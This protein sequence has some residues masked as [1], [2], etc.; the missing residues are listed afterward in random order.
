MS[1]AEPVVAGP[2]AASPKRK[3][4]S[5]KAKAQTTTTSAKRVL[6]KKAPDGY[7]PSPAVRNLPTNLQDD[8]LEWWNRYIGE[9]FEDALGSRGSLY[10]NGRE[11]VLFKFYDEFIPDVYGDINW[12]E[13]DKGWYYQQIGLDIYHFLHRRTTRGGKLFVP[14]EQKVPLPKKY[15]YAHDEWRNNNPDI[16]N[17]ILAKAVAE[18]GG[19]LGV[20]PRQ[21][22]SRSE[23]KKLSKDEQSKW[24]QAAK[25]RLTT[26]NALC[27]LENPEE[28]ERQGASIIKRLLALIK[29]AENTLGIQICAQLL[30]PQSKDN[31]K[32]KSLYARG[33]EQFA[34]TGSLDEFLNSLS[35]YVEEN[36]GVSVEG[37]PARVSILPDFR[38]DKRPLMPEITQHTRLAALQQLLRAYITLLWIFQGGCTKVP[39]D[40]IGKDIDNWIDPMRRPAS[41]SWSDPGS[42]P[43]THVLQWFQYIQDGQDGVV[44]PD[45]AFQFRRVVAASKTLDPS[46]SQATSRETVPSTSGRLV[47]HLLFDDRVTRCQVPG[48]IAY[49]KHCMDY[50]HHLAVR[51]AQ[52]R[53]PE[54]APERWLGLPP[55]NPQ[56]SRAAIDGEEKQT[57]MSLAGRLPA[58][59]RKRVEDFVEAINDHEGNLPASNTKGAWGCPTKPPS[60]IPA[61]PPQERPPHIFSPI[62][63][64]IEFY[65]N[66]LDAPD[67]STIPHSL[68]WV[69]AVL[70]SDAMH[71]QPSGTLLGGE[72]GVAWP[73]RVLLKVFLNM[74]AVR[75]FLDSPN[76]LPAGYDASMLDVDKWDTTLGLMDSYVQALEASTETLS[77]TSQER[78]IGLAPSNP[79]PAAAEQDPP[80][81]NES[82]DEAPPNKQ[83]RKSRKSSKS[84]RKPSKSSRS[85][86]KP[87]E[88]LAQS[89][90]SEPESEDEDYD[91]LDG[92]SDSVD[93]DNGG[94]EF[95]SLTANLLN[96]NEILRDKPLDQAAPPRARA[97][98]K[99]PLIKSLQNPIAPNDECAPSAGAWVHLECIFGAV[100][101]LP[102]RTPF[103]GEGVSE[104][105]FYLNLIADKASQFLA[106]WLKFDSSYL[107]LSDEDKESAA[108]AAADRPAELRPLFDYVFRRRLAWRHAVTAAPQAHELMYRFHEWLREFLYV[109]AAIERLD[110]QI[111]GTT[112]A[113]STTYQ[114]LMAR[115]NTS[116]PIAA[117]LRLKYHELDAYKTFAGWWYNQCSGD[118]LFNDLESPNRLQ[119]VVRTQIKW[120]RDVPKLVQ[121]LDDQRR[122]A[123]LDL[124]LTTEGGGSTEYSVRYRFGLPLEAEMPDDLEDA[125]GRL[126]EVISNADVNTSTDPADTPEEP[127]VVPHSAKIAE[128]TATTSPS[129][130]QPPPTLPTQPDGPPTT[131]PNGLLQPVPTPSA[132]SGPSAPGME[133]DDPSSAPSAGSG[134]SA[135]SASPPR[136]TPAA[137]LATPVL[138]ALTKPLANAPSDAPPPSKSRKKRTHEELAPSK[139][140]VRRVSARLQPAV[141]DEAPAKP[142]KTR[143]SRA[144][145]SASKGRKSR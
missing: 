43:I 135:P 117:E 121:R 116:K 110:S 42:M 19:P 66:W 4:K 104:V 35:D 140:V 62:W 93:D 27:R 99:R 133:L 24:K 106:D 36:G 31:Y 5:K 74:A 115:V 77:H 85:A 53:A 2:P 107:L 55:A 59:L 11:F 123:R 57:V 20:H 127:N 98:K 114:S 73:G 136:P 48:G 124:D 113:Q 97:A 92:D 1:D 39:W 3:K 112:A 108:R 44:L 75:R 143:A 65:S 103:G 89:S 137:H 18:N 79:F 141:Q 16:W 83:G 86:R 49:P 134:P 128:P 132:E 50:A 101:P 139:P 17:P 29:E 84:S 6:L 138:P 111:Q 126:P 34:K 22:L 80:V 131:E 96:L 68:R 64:P 142:P 78:E 8:Q 15:A 81:T 144:K 129:P 82:D 125:L 38:N 7:R 70:A 45:R 102:E 23:F 105:L 25:D 28:R 71:H 41:A 69:K 60:F 54:T 91:G 10:D 95:E 90:A 58:D 13:N 32:I 40:K 100:K 37:D 52:S 61:T 56:S 88:G 26:V 76:P 118:W 9:E 130:P 12:T 122:E 21:E 14:R 94:D 72:T 51:E 46:E 67:E 120:C 30:M 63:L 119:E 145:G 33:L 47:L 87:K 109:Y